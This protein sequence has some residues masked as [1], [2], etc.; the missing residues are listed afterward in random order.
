MGKAQ[1]PKI[2]CSN[3]G[4]SLDPSWAHLAPRPP[5]P[6]CGHRGV[7]IA[8]GIVEEINV[9][10]SLNVVM[11]PHDTDRNWRRRWTELE[12][13]WSNIDR[14]IAETM[15]GVAI[16]AANHR[17]QSFYIQAYHFKDALK[18]VAPDVESAIS[19]HPALALLA[20]LANL[21]KHSQLNRSPRSGE[22]PTI[23][24]L[25]G[26]ESG[27]GGGWRLRLRIHHKGQTLDGMNV[28]REAMD[29]WRAYLKTSG[30]LET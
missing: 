14:P 22:V 29:G 15:S 11:H 24:S 7:A 6:A 12:R 8:V 18:S 28:A 2:S 1:P 9:A 20:D 19:A 16:N 3:C 10:S 5:C 30:L 4:E 26:E 25:S 23:V 27:S 17:L 21:D 13:E